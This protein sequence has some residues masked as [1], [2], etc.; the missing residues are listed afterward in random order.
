MADTTSSQQSEGPCTHHL[1]SGGLSLFCEIEVTLG[2]AS[3]PEVGPWVRLPPGPWT[4]ESLQGQA[5]QGPLQPRSAAP[6]DPA[7]EAGAGAMQGLRLLWS[8]PS[9]PTRSCAPT[10]LSPHPPQGQDG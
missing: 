9:A 6:G 2:V 5:P 7:Q 10:E 3:Q 1:F 8:E 4:P